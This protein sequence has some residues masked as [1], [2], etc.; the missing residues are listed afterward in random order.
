MRLLCLLLAVLAAAP[1]LADS[2][3][4]L[5][6]PPP[7]TEIT[8]TVPS[9][10]EEVVVEA[11]EPRYVAATRRDRIGRVWA[12]V[13]INGQGPFRLVLDTGASGSA[14]IQSAV[15]RL[16]MST[17]NARMIN[18]RGVT[19]S[20]LVPSVPVD[21]IE[22]GDL[23]LE[24]KRLPVVP[25]AFG[26]AEGVLGTEGLVDKRIYIDFGRDEI[27]I[28]RS[29]RQDAPAGFTRVPMTLDRNRLP[30]FDVLIGSIRVKAVLD[31]GAQITV[32][33]Q[34]LRELLTRRPVGSGQP[35]EIIGVTLDVAVGEVVPTPVMHI[36]AIDVHG[37]RLTFG[38]MFIFKHW[39][40]TREPA[41]L[42]GMDVIGSFDVLV[43]D[44]KKRELQIRARRSG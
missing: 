1:G 18:L 14:I 37:L 41:L 13:R 32:G 36:G 38:D 33:N 25:D 2:V 5:T 30:T 15:T 10:P 11:V 40:L 23:L 12:P 17:L 7:G 24:G 39:K 29:R 3:P 4:K 31:T 20:A 22:V 9:V 42:I 21:R 6:E 8:T 19:G 34:A 43:I 28:T 26:G 44:Y 27:S 35:Q 16:G